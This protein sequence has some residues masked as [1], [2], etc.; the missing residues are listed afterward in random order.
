MIMLVFTSSYDPALGLEVQNNPSLNV[1]SGENRERASYGYSVHTVHID[2]WKIYHV[3]Y[4]A[5]KK[6]VNAKR[7]RFFSSSLT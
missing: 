3:D 1:A 5:R 2:G 6:K 4:L 7:R